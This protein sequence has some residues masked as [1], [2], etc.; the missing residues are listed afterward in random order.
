MNLMTTIHGRQAIAAAALLMMLVASAASAAPA[1]IA[2]R[3]IPDVDPAD[4]T[5][6][7]GA[8]SDSGRSLKASSLE[9]IIDG[10]RASEPPTMQPLSEW[11]TTAAEASATWRPPVSVGLVYLWVTGVPSGVLD[12]IQGFFQRV[13]SRTTVYPTIY[14]RMRQ[15]RARLTAADVSRLGDVAYLEGYRPNMIDAIRLE[16]PDLAADT[17]ALKILLLVTD[18]RDFADPKG[19]GP[20]D[21][22]VLGRDLRKAG[23][24][25]LI[26]AIPAPEA[27]AA[28][29]TA[30]LRELHDAAGGF[31]RSLDQTS[32][33]E[34]TL[35]SLG[36]SVADLQ[37]VRFTTPFSWR[38]FGGS[39]RLLV[40]QTAAGGQRL[41]ADIGMVS[42]A[43]SGLRWLLVALVLVIA[44]VVGGAVVMM[45]GRRQPAVGRSSSR[46]GRGDDDDD[47]DRDGDDDGDR[48]D[49]D[50]EEIL[51]AAHDLIRRGASPRR[52]VEELSR[53]FPEGV[54]SLVQVDQE[55]LQDPR[56][57]YFR[58]RPGR[59]RLQEIRD[60]LAKKSAAVPTLTSGLAAVLAEAVE[61]QM[62]AEQAAE[63]LAARVGADEWTAFAGL[64]LDRLA[65]A[66]RASSRSHP[67][68]A[69]PRARGVAVAIQD[70]L[71]AGSGS[72]GILVG[73]L[74][75]TGG[76]GRRGETLR[77]SG[78]GRCV[79][80]QA[81]GCAIRIT[82]DGTIAPEH[83]VFTIEGSAFVIAPLGG[84]LSVEG[85]TVPE[86]HVLSDGETIGLGAGLFI[87]KSAS[88]GNLSSGNVGPRSA[89]RAPAVP[90]SISQR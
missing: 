77:I 59:M 68:L 19:D 3:P 75:R 72:H 33:I 66:L 56:F 12:G 52:A 48:R 58:T 13:P 81:P 35:E 82:G 85:A 86:R 90:R 29:A 30:N 15:G 78:E 65:E 18:G 26:V 23:V 9:L 71:R 20:G 89:R 80:G 5:F 10:E 39:H 42:A 43:P 36:Q 28:Q 50:G 51:Q 87:F 62:P 24:T 64:D 17:A 25:P 61:S 84:S 16:L 88:A 27:D 38:L 1:V 22:S 45:K 69:R 73:W 6:F 14:G 31:L 49:D 11:A 41:N 74:V 53:S 47:D 55:T 34:N 8:I 44:G 57:P 46:A 32:D 79:V 54:S 4:L 67:L 37:R 2:T 21:F 60:I 7:V 76:P 63:M 40:R 70:A 83:A